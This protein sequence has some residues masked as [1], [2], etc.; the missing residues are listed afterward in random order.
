MDKASYV[1]IAAADS[2]AE[3]KAAADFVCGGEHDEQTLASALAE[4]D[5]L[6]KNAY[7]YNGV[8]N[9][10]GFRDVGDGGPRAAIVLPRSHRELAIIGQNHEYGIQKSFRNGVV[11]YVSAAALTCADGAE[12]SVVRGGW[13]EAGIQNGSSLRMENLAVA[14]ANN[15][16]AVRCVDLRRTDRAEIKNLTM[17]S[18]GDALEN[19]GVGLDVTAPLPKKGCIGLTMTDGSNYNYSNYTNVH[20]YGFDEGIQVGGEHVVCV[21][22][23][24]TGGNYGFTFGNYEVHCGSNHP[25]TLINC[26]DERNV[27]LPYF[28]KWCGDEA[29]GGKTRLRGAQEVTFVGFNIERTAEHTP[30]GRLGELMREEIPG[31]WRGSVDFT[32]QTAWNSLNAV[33]FK[34]W[35]SDGSGSGMRTRNVCHKAVCGTLERLSYYPSFGQQVFDTDL[36][37]ML[38]CVDPDLKKWVDFDGREA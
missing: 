9:I 34:L 21:N 10:D 27:N 25:I 11:F 36:N 30:G 15:A 19:D 3:A 5:R 20:A 23:G 18:Y 17:I 14:L 6:G 31:L 38:V 13:T 33:D 26:L 29:P 35:E 24:A 1:Y 32:A 8:Y 22:C 28:G 7:L 16:Q 2:G 4:C 37:K 12:A